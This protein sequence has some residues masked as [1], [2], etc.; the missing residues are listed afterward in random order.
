[1]PNIKKL[2]RGNGPSGKDAA[3]GYNDKSWFGWRFDDVEKT[4]YDSAWH[5]IEFN[6]WGAW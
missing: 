3:A 6:D 4:C 1:M 5:L 2:I